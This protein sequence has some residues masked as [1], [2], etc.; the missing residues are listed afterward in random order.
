MNAIRTVLCAVDFSGTGDH[1]LEQAIR[2]ARRHG[3][4]LVLGHVIEPI[5]VGA[6]PD[7]QPTGSDLELR[8]LAEK[9]VEERAG[10]IRD[11][12]LEVA[13]RVAEGQPGPELVTLAETEGADLVV[14]GTKGLSAVPHLL[15]G[16]VAESVVRRCPVPVLTVHPDDALL[17]Q[18][19]ERVVL[20]TDLSPKAEAALDVFEAWFG[21]FER[22]LVLVAFAD[23]VPP[24]L[25]PFRHEALEKAGKPDAERARIEAEMQPI[26]SRLHDD[27]FGT[28][29][30]VVDGTPPDAIPALARRERADLI[31]MSTHGRSALMNALMGRTAQRIVQFAPCPVLTVRAR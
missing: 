24:Y 22:P 12:G 23:R 15:L 28:E 26:V 3:A 19:I 25:E 9:R 8:P 1:A 21:G 29:L 14:I 30:H 2:L 7:I 31:V 10:P 16:S 13:V 4:R 11:Q 17:G 6:Y 18:S 20:P 27:G 5:P